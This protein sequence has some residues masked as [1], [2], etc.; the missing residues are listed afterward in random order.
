MTKIKKGGILYNRAHKIKKFQSGAYVPQQKNPSYTNGFYYEDLSSMFPGLSGDNK[1]SQSGVNPN[2]SLDIFK[3]SYTGFKKNS[4]SS[5][6]PNEKSKPFGE[7]D[8]SDITKI[9]KPSIDKVGLSGYDPNSFTATAEPLKEAKPAQPPFDTTG[10]RDAGLGTISKGA[11]MAG[12]ALQGTTDDD[13]KTYTGKEKAGTVG[14][15]ALSGAGAGLSAGV[16]AAGLGVGT[17]SMA[18]SLTATGALASTI[19][20][21]Q[22]AVPVPVVGA[23]IG[24]VVGIVTGIF[25]GK[26]KKKQARKAKRDHSIKVRS[27]LNAQIRKHNSE[28]DANLTSGI[29]ATSQEAPEV[30]GYRSRRE[31]GTF[32]YTIPKGGNLVQEILAPK[33]FKRGGVVTPTEN[34]IPNGVLHEENNQLGDKGMPVVK[35]ASKDS[36][37]KQYEIERDEMILTQ[38]TTKTI[39][40][41]SAKKKFKELGEF[42]KQQILDNTHSFTGKYADLNNYK[43]D[44][45][46]IYN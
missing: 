6:N 10:G 11:Q 35:C 28:Q 1:G 43:K 13:D 26:K 8:Y 24:L 15:S 40:E 12:A 7:K 34:I 45:G 5:F 32:H 46:T 4:T 18:G 27:Q 38:S 42:V 17:V 44:N 31:G 37:S 9:N 39:E 29:P 16:S 2:S 25:K 23:A 30:N 20:I 41:L 14:G 21:G 22:M 36:C 19:A 3:D 33:K